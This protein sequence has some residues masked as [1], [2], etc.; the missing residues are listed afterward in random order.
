MKYHGR[1]AKRDE[2]E[3]AIVDALEACGW[4]VTRI[5]ITDWPDLHIGKPGRSIWLEV[6]TGDNEQSKGQVE[7][8]ARMMGF[9]MDVRV[10][11]TVEETL[12]VVDQVPLPL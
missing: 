3:P 4:K 12:L 2:S 10:V 1:N 11:R 9:G 7:Q 8:M 6:K 5:S